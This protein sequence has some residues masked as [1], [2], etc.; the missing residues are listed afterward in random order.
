MDSALPLGYYEVQ[1]GHPGAVAGGA[2]TPPLETHEVH[3]MRINPYLSFDGCCEAAFRHYAESLRGTIEMMLSYGE[4]PGA[5]EIPPAYRG[6]II[7]ARLAVGDQVLMGSDC[8]PACPYEPIRGVS[9]SLNVDSV[10]EAERL[11]AALAKD[12]TVQMPLAETFWAE[13]FAMFI[14]RFGV[15]WMINCEKKQ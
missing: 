9:V 4:A 14:D 11:Y 5:E 10:A 1:T 12:G 3:E 15:P 7:H 8:T 2:P 13:R 6:K